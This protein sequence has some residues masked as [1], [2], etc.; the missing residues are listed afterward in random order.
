MKWLNIY[1][2]LFPAASRVVRVLYID[3]RDMYKP[4]KGDVT[5]TLITSSL[6]GLDR[7]HINIAD[8]EKTDSC[9]CFDHIG[10]FRLFNQA[11][12]HG[13]YH[14]HYIKL[15]GRSAANEST[16]V[17]MMACRRTDDK[18]NA[19]NRQWRRT[20]T[21]Q[22]D[23]KGQCVCTSSMST[24]WCKARTRYTPWHRKT[25][26]LCIVLL[27]LCHHFFLNWCN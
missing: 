3:T 25:V 2:K 19:L 17:Y 10:C 4:M 24:L 5:Y 14:Q 18:I 20:R 27:C 9:L 22:C 6:I 16:L 8:R 12:R 26:L 1:L 11:H 21:H 23:T 13:R 7:S 15:P